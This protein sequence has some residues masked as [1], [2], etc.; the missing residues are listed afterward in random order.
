MT[1]HDIQWRQQHTAVSMTTAMTTNDVMKQLLL[2][3]V[4]CH[5][6]A[7]LS[8]W[9]PL[10][11]SP[12][13]PLWHQPPLSFSFSDVTD[14]CCIH[15]NGDVT[16]TVTCPASLWCIHTSPVKW[17]RPCDTRRCTKHPHR[18]TRK[19]QLCHYLFFFT[20]SIRYHNVIILAAI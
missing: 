12:R 9:Q 15:D 14:T 13:Q 2:V 20:C 7:V 11:S 5:S 3:S 1:S 4:V 18:D 8:P 6:Q 10:L 16:A 17:L 19:S